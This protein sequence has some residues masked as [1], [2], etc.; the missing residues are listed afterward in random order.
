MAINATG[1]TFLFLNEWTTLDALTARIFPGGVED[2]GAH[3][4]GVVVYIDRAL[5][6]PYQRWRPMYRNG[7]R[8]L[9]AHTIATCQKLFVELTESE[10][11]DVI[12]DLE[13]G[14]LPGFNGSDEGESGAAAFFTMIWAHTVEGMFC[15]PAYGGNRDAVGWKLIGFPGAQYGYSR[16]DR[17]Y[18]SDL[19][20]K[21]IMT[22]GDI[23]Q[24]TQERPDL[25]Y[26]RPG[27]DPLASKKEISELP[28][29]SRKPEKPLILGV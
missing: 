9:N 6:G 21:P 23:T 19:S 11:D 20:H 27:P 5:A 29:A 22:L 17:S 8:A 7:L 24:L 12:A 10:Q 2:P 4:A 18:G 1:P 28:E 16:E 15:D 14:E 26:H 25:F 3:E 13:K